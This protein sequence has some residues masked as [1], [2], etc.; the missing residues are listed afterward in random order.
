MQI[1]GGGTIGIRLSLS[2]M[3]ARTAAQTDGSHVAAS[4][5]Y[6]TESAEI[7]IDHNRVSSRLITMPYLVIKTIKASLPY[8]VPL[9]P[10]PPALSQPSY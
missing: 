7:A 6:E 4:E 9:S 2:K 3:Q 1:F 8:L 5:R 10:Q